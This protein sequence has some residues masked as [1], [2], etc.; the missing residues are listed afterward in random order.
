MWLR[1][2]PAPLLWIHPI[3]KSHVLMP[4]GDSNVIFC[5]SGIF[6]VG[7]CPPMKMDTNF[8]FRQSEAAGVTLRLFGRHDRPARLLPKHGQRKTAP[9]LTKQ[10]CFVWSGRRG[11]NS[12]PPP[13]QGG[14]LP[15][16]LRPHKKITEDCSV[17]F[18]LA[19]PVRLERTTP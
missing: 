5:S 14:A 12:L 11:S 1:H 17:I 6:I 8:L 2:A 10:R 3:A 15:D 13:W 9:F 18:L 7:T 4:N 19:A 16:E